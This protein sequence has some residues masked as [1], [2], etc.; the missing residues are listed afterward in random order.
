MNYIIWTRNNRV[1]T[2]F[3]R[4]IARFQWKYQAGRG[5][6]RQISPA[7]LSLAGEAHV[8]TVDGF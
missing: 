3:D 1:I 2:V 8:S 7:S 6:V 5:R 4:L